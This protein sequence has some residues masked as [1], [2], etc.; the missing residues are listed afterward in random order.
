MRSNG[1][2]TDG[3]Y[4]FLWFHPPRQ[5]D[6]SAA[7]NLND[8]VYVKWTGAG[9]RA[10]EENHRKCLGSLADRYPIFEADC[11][12]DGWSKVRLWELMQIAGPHLT[13]GMHSPLFEENDIRLTPPKTDQG[14]QEARAAAYGYSPLTNG[15]PPC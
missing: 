9:L 1:I 5:I 13:M 7:M 11:D 12:N 15:S 6:E 3:C 8:T 2:L 4:L 14:L 10:V